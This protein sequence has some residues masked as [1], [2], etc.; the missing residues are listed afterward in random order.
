MMPEAFLAPQ[1]RRAH[2][3]RR[4]LPVAARRDP[5]GL[6]HPLLD[7]QGPQ[8]VPALL[9]QRLPLPAQPDPRA[10]L[11]LR[12]VQARPA[13]RVQP[14]RFQARPVRREAQAQP[15]LLRLLL[16]RRVRPGLHPRFQAQLEAKVR[17]V[18]R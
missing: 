3:V 11:D 14:P 15:E 5:L 13:P 8:A 4:A 17:R 6:L 2:R 1:A 7:R 9:V 12:G 16:A 10:V 18:L